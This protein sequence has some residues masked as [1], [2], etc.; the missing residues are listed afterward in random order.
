MNGKDLL[1]ILTHLFRKKGNPVQVE[2]A[3]E[4]ISFRCRY[5][6]PSQVRRLLTMAMKNEMVSRA[7]DSLS[8]KFLYDRQN[9]SP[10]L[11]STLYD[12]VRLDSDV[13]PMYQVSAAAIAR[14]D[15]NSA[16]K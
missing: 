16:A 2:D 9:L 10:N 4:F 11:A 14:S 15:A 3:V 5:G 8:A 1:L 13:E 7:E 12:K 6:R